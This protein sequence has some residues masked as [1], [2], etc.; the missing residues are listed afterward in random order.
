[1][2][3]QIEN[4]KSVTTPNPVEANQEASGVNPATLEE[5]PSAPQNPEETMDR[6]PPEAPQSVQPDQPM[7]YT[8]PTEANEYT[9]AP[10]A[11]PMPEGGFSEQTWADDDRPPPEAPQSI[12]SDQPM[13]YT[14]PTEA[15]EYTQAPSAPPMPEGGFSAEENTSSDNSSNPDVYMNN[16]SSI[17][18]A[19][20]TEHEG[21]VHNAQ[22]IE[23]G[24]TEQSSL[25]KKEKES[26]ETTNPTA[27]MKS[28]PEKPNPAA[29]VRSD[30]LTKRP[31]NS[32][33]YYK[34]YNSSQSAEPHY[35]SKPTPLARTQVSAQENIENIYHFLNLPQDAKAKAVI[36]SATRFTL[37]AAYESA[38]KVKKNKISFPTF[39]AI[40]KSLSAFLNC[41]KEVFSDPIKRAAYDSSLSSLQDTPNRSPKVEILHDAGK[42]EQNL[43]K[44]LAGQSL[45]PGASQV[46]ENDQI[47]YQSPTPT[48]LTHT[49]K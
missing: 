1:M 36:E 25:E 10:S 29:M 26:I 40:L 33:Y 27:S 38:G 12:Q 22:K 7:L 35:H 39:F 32:G 3:A 30:K 41:V 28:E 42:R 34:N 20:L 31:S 44:I 37:T 6:P 49:R 21:I 13:L 24:D 2:A 15:N 23:N 14:S 19:D 48:M 11:P 17:N 4:E 46:K 8:S 45:T 16:A 9:Q 47:S 43:Y 5:K 18:P